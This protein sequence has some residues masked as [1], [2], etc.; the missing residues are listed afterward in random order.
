VDDRDVALA[1]V[2]NVN[3]LLRRIPAERVDARAVLI[4]A[5]TLPVLASTTTDVLLQPEKDAVRRFVVRDAG[6]PFAR[7]ERPRRRR[8]PRL[9]VDHLDRV[10]AFVVDEDVSL[11]VGRGAFRRGVLELDGGDDVA[12]CGSSAVSVPIGRL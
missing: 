10:L 12:V 9:D 1:A 5:T 11:A 2:R 7:R 4:V 6:R 8:L 3:Q